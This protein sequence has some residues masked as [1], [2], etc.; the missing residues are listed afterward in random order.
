MGI[1]VDI[2]HR[3]DKRMTGYAT[4]LIKLKWVTNP[5]IVYLQADQR[6]SLLVHE[7]VTWRV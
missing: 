5:Y 7:T 6:K 3:I 2:E 4:T 1:D